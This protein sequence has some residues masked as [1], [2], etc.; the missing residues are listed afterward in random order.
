NPISYLTGTDL[1][2]F[3]N[4]DTFQSSNVSQVLKE[5]IGC[6]ICHTMSGISETVHAGDNVAA[7]AT[8]KMY[9]LG[10]IKFGPI[11]DPEP[12]DYHES[13][14]LP[15]YNTSQMCLPCHDLVVRDIEAEI[16]FTEWDR[17]P[18]F[19]MFGGVS[20]QE[21]HMPMKDNGYHDHSF[22]GVDMDLS[23][24]LDINP[25]YEQVS[26]LL[27]NSANISF[28]FLENT[29]PNFI[30][31]GDTLSI[32]ISI[33]SQTAHSIPSGTSFNRESWIELIVKND[34]NII[35]SSGVINNDESLDITEDPQ[36]LIFSS[37]MYDEEGNPTNNITDMHSMDNYSLSAYQER[38]HFYNVYIPDSIDGNIEIY[39]RLL[40][41]SLKPEF[42]LLHHPEFMDNLPVFEIDSINQSITISNE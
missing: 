24:P 29:L 22:I 8:Y 2:Q 6:D 33:E 32:P 30:I 35:Y 1:S 37:Y 23:I 16:T 40:F 19:S 15:T 11:V 39:A 12:N 34:N 36:L 31:P 14:Y 20:C 3:N 10:N 13:Y 28:N 41:R 4:P 38:Y 21:C 26:N 9:P 18:G 7:N 27:S 5:G 17:I 42:V 25:L